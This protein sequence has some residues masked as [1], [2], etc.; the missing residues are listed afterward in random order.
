MSLPD[1]TTIVGLD[2]EHLPEMLA[3]WPTWVRHRPQIPAHPVIVVAD[4]FVTWREITQ[5]M[6]GIN[7]Q[8]VR[9][10]WPADWSQR[11]RMLTGLVRAVE[12]VRTEWFLKVDTDAVAMNG[13]PDG[14]WWED[15]WFSGDAVLIASPWGYTKPAENL[16]KCDEWWESFPITI[17]QRANAGERP[18]R[19]IAGNIAKHPRIISYAMWGR[20]DW[21]VRMWR[22]CDGRMPCPSQDTFL[23]YCAVRGGWPIVRAKQT[24]YGWTHCGSSLKRVRERAAEALK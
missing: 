1:F 23:G 4:Q 11:E 20:T 3:A 24:R 12:W 16:T 10:D 22:L 5:V 19:T 13:G 2:Q 17:N 18:P 8:V 14:R 15:G 6:T 9:F 21:T 7:P